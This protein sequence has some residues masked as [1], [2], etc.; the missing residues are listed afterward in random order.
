MN[1]DGSL[2]GASQSARPIRSWWARAVRLCRPGMGLKRWL[3]I[4]AL[5]IAVSS[6]GFA[7]LLRK[8][9]ELRFPDFLP[10]YFEGIL[11]VGGGAA[12]ILLAIYGLY[13]S[14]APLIREAANIDSLA[15]T[16]YTRRSRVRGPR[17]VAIGG[18]TGLSVL[19][20]GLKAHTDNMTAII[21]VADDGG[22]SGRLRRELGVLPPGDF[23]NCLVAMS[24][25]ETLLTD[26]FQYRF[27]GGDGL[28]GHSFGNLF[29]VAMSSVADSFERALLESSRVL[30][31]H[32]QIV[33]ATVANLKLSARMRDGATVSGESN[34][35]GRGG[36]VDR[37]VIEPEDAEAFPPAVEA[38]EQA[39]MVVM[40][41]GSL[42]TSILPN[43][44]VPGIAQA[45]KKTKA[46][47]VYVCN[48]ATEKGETDEFGVADH[49]DV[50][51]EHMFPGVADYVI[52]NSSPRDLG[53]QFSGQP[54]VV[55]RRPLRH[56]KL[57]LADVADR[58]HR[59]RHDPARLARAIVDIFARSRAKPSW[60]AAL[61]PWP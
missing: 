39:Q 19:L 27:D 61:R 26:L 29:L 1:G 49:V 17:I 6:I 40:G 33:P 2:N 55:G 14:I 21:S 12:V 58:D 36:Q 45:L 8:L 38:I 41:P 43:L 59:V 53:P 57:E 22:S 20:R 4:G 25:S 13:R 52:A 54:V 50:L 48:V 11:L 7:F 3:L 56:A 18:G 51:E 23:R 34:I 35:T 28:K 30:A 16:I 5:G 32:G 31:V 24:E 47:K 15:D 37:L 10:S 60:G 44:L 9:F 46:P 42:Y